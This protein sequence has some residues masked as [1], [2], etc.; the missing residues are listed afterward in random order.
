MLYPTCRP[1]LLAGLVALASLFCGCNRNPNVNVEGTVLK[2]GQ[3]IPVS[4]TGYVQVTLHPDVGPDVPF[5]P[6]IAEC[7][8]ATG[9]FEIRE[10]L[11]GKYKIG[12]EQFDPNPQIDKLNSAFRAD[13]GKIIREIDGKTPLTIDIAKPGAG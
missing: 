1:G 13:T 12:V 7:D 4:A 11:P 2:N 5:T 10:V 9:K 8:R 6:R 3:P